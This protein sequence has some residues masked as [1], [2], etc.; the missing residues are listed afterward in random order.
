MSDQPDVRKALE[1]LAQRV[2]KNMPDQKN[3]K[4]VDINN[5]AK[6]VTFRW[7]ERTFVVNLQ[8]RVSELKGNN[9]F[10]TGYS[11]LIQGILT[12]K[13]QNEQYID[14]AILAITGAE[15]YA[16]GKQLDLMHQKLESARSLL[17]RLTP[18]GKSEPIKVTAK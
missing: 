7:H 14:A 15:D 10:V 16:R 8:F 9:L 6:I 17:S 18:Q 1:E 2:R 11:M 4:E 3:L 5:D 13:V 12:S